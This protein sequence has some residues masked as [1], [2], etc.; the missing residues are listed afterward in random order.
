MESKEVFTK[1]LNIWII[2]NSVLNLDI[3][4]PSFGLSNTCSTSPRLGN[5]YISLLWADK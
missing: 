3:H 4:R 2:Y 5:E 1:F